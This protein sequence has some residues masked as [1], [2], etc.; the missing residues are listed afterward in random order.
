MN[1]RV[2][3][4]LMWKHG[5]VRIRRF[6]HTIV[7]VVSPLLFFLLLFAFKSSVQL[8]LPDITTRNEVAQTDE[9]SLT[10]NMQAPYWILYTPDTPL[11]ASLMDDVGPKLDLKRLT[12]FPEGSEKGY[13]PYTNESQLGDYTSKM[14]LMEAII[15]FHNMDGETWPGRLNY[16]I[17]MKD[18]FKTD[19]YEPLDDTPGPHRMFGLNYGTFMRIQWAVDTSYIKLLTGTEVPV[20]VS[21]QE[22]PYYHTQRDAMAHFL[23]ALLMV[24]CY[25]SLMLNFVFLMCR[26][27]EERTSGIQE[28]IKMVGVSLNTLGLSHFLNALPSGLMFSIGGTILLKVTSKPLV[29]HSDG[30]LIFLMLILYFNSIIAMAFACSYA[31]RGTRYAATLSVMFYVMMWLPARLLYDK[32]KPYWATILTGFFPHTPMQWFWAEVANMETY[33]K[34]LSF[35]DIATSHHPENPPVLVSYLFMIVQATIFYFVAWYLSLVRPGQYGQALPWNYLFKSISVKRSKRKYEEVSPASEYEL[36]TRFDA[37]KYGEACGVVSDYGLQYEAG[38]MERAPIWGGSDIST[39]YTCAG[40]DTTFQKYSRKKYKLATF[41]D[42]ERSDYSDYGIRYDV[43]NINKIQRWITRDIDIIADPCSCMVMGNKAQYWTKNEV[44]PNEEVEEEEPIAYDPRYFE[45]P[46]PNMEPGIKIVNVSKMY[47]KHKALRNVSLEVYKGEITVL[48]GHNGAGK[49]TL[50]SIITGMTSATEGRV[51]VNGKDTVSQQAEVRQ[52]LGLCPQHN[53]FFGDLT[54]QEHIIFFTLLKRGTYWS[55]VESSRLLAERLSLEDKLGALPGELSGGMKRRAQLACALAGGAD[56]LVLDEPTS[57]LDVETRRELW[58]LLL[59]LRGERTV[60]LTTHFMEEADALGDRVAAL[61]AGSLRCHATTMHLKKAVG[62]GY[63]L[64]FTT[65]GLPRDAAITAVVTAHVVDATIKEKTINSISYNLP[66]TATQRF[67]KLFSALE[68]MRSEL[69]IDSIGV[70]VSTLE[71]VFLKLCSDVDTTMIEDEIDQAGDL[72]EPARRLTGL[73]LYMRQLLVLLKRQVKYSMH[74]I[75]PF[76]ILQLVLPIMMIFSITHLCNNTLESES[77]RLAMELDVYSLRADRR[78]LYRLPQDVSLEPL[79]RRYST[80]RFEQTDDVAETVL[81]T[82]MKD[83]L[84]Y[85][86]YLVGVELN[87]TDAKVLYTTTVRHAAPVGLNLLSNVLASRYIAWA[88]GRSITTLNDPITPDARYTPA[89]QKMPKD[90]T[91]VVFW[92]LAITFIILATNINCISLPCKERATGSRHIHVMCGCPAELHWAATLIFHVL[93]CGASL[94]IPTLIAAVTLDHDSTIDQA[95]MIVTFSLIVLLGSMAFFAFMY[96]V[97]FNFEERATS[98]ILVAVIIVFGI[99]T[100]S[101]K[102]AQDILDNEPHGITYIL[103]TMCEYVAPPHTMVTAAMRCANVGRLNAWC[104]LARQQCPN[105]FINQNG[106]D[107]DKCCETGKARCYFCID[108]YSPAQLIIVLIVQFFA[109]MTMVMLTERGVFNGLVDKLLNVNYRASDEPRVD[110]MV[111]AEKAYVSK[112]ITLPSKQIPDAMLVDDLHKCY[113]PLLQPRCNAVKG[114]SFSVKKGECFGLLGVNGAGKSTT[115]KMLT[116]EESA[117]RGNIYGNGYHLKRGNAKYL[118]TLGYC[119]QFFGLDMFQ[120]GEE[121]LALVLTL[122]GFDQQRVR[123]EV[124]SWIQIVG[125]EKYA[126]RRVEAYSGGC[127]RRLGAAAAL[128]GSAELVLLDEPSAGVDVAARRRL[129]AA[130][131]RALRHQRAV[132]ITSHSMDEME[133]LCSRIAILA[134]G[135][136]R[137]LGTAATLRAQHAQGHAVVFKVK[138]QQQSDDE[139]DSSAGAKT[140]MHHFKGKLQE[141]FNCTL[142]DEHKTMLHYHI[143][144]TMRYSELFTEL[145]ALRHHFPALIEDYSVTETTLEEVFLSFAKEQ[146]NSTQTA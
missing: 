87:E 61:N 126:K 17:R 95:D 100:P 6:I 103:L 123:H 15:I 16:T 144:E 40:D 89:V 73:P 109:M 26:L 117:T 18:M 110:D 137:A 3:S 107:A 136:V 48:V 21:L 92:A 39:D 4:V 128:C 86:K 119:P 29:A 34:G 55:A 94:V 63:R 142:K 57:G 76:T 102:A 134:G 56:V 138:H 85:N 98:V 79:T 35:A 114:V 90:T 5:V 52:N 62:T 127:V 64:Q 27:L 113:V 60:L 120:T 19:S 74:K 81:Q 97:S 68:N 125:L 104:E 10:E 122:R 46:P 54:V 141:K 12:H 118:Q 82:A 50:M 99:L 30:V 59:S 121:N 2:L 78:V 106:F 84:E 93:L 42:S 111:R 22:F 69:G 7:D 65:I 146:Q 116:A 132:I 135:R 51:Y 32:T 75:V 101:M 20:S 67:P 33:G 130:L 131:R 45:P 11:T 66:A 41:G 38:N 53:L 71:E 1:T 80:V 91:G 14:R 8:N 36:M 129:W 139:V 49:T 140:Q 83:I 24:V 72:D 37:L 47:P 115:F 145:E 58:D 28:L 77:V 124:N 25:L 108:Q 43:R 44:Q 31:S 13:Y 96:L 112:A 133:A 70:G 23:C 143:N 88:D 9:L 105:V